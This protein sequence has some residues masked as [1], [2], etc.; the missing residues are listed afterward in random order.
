MGWF[1][2]NNDIGYLICNRRQY[3][4]ATPHF[5]P[6]ARSPTPRSLS[7]SRI[8]RHPIHTTCIC[9]HR[10]VCTYSTARQGCRQRVPPLW[11]LQTDPFRSHPWT[12][13]LVAY[14]CN[15]WSQSNCE[16]FHHCSSLG[17][18]KNQELSQSRKCQGIGNYKAE[19]AKI[20][21][22]KL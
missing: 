18:L 15:S 2:A 16:T 6:P 17:R 11:R 10:P 21:S 9:I 20:Q 8:R 19:S 22:R 7:L 1:V 3:R 13:K 5:I 12:K 14:M 4:L